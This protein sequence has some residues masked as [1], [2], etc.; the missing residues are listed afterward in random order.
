MAIN[1]NEHIDQLFR[2][3]IEQVEVRYNPAHWQ[4]LNAA[5]SAANTEQ[6]GDDNSSSGKQLRK[7]YPGWWL[8]VFVGIFMLTAL[9]LILFSEKNGSIDFI[10]PRKEKAI[11]HNTTDSILPKN[12]NESGIDEPKSTRSTL[13][14][15]N[16]STHV[17]KPI[18]SDSLAQDSTKGEPDLFIFW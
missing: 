13:E 9:F 10:S 15:V 11:P 8:S 5:L 17:L 2:D 6:S 1:N 14:S 7:G 16:D 12:P 3:G 18:K 4:Q